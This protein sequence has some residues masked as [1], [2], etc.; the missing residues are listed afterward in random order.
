M[1][2]QTVCLF[3]KYGFC[4][5]KERCLKLHIDD[6]CADSSCNTSS[7]NRRHPKECRYYRKY[8]RCKL[9]PCKFLHRENDIDESLKTKESIDLKLKII[10]DKIKKLS[11]KIIASESSYAEKYQKCMA[12]LENR[13]EI[14]E[15]NLNTSQ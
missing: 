4:K 1:A 5:F 7:C 15:T 12:D 13:L 3:N 8:R 14:F 2:A 11:E 10:D 9:D 6:Y